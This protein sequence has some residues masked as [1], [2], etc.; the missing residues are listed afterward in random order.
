MTSPLLSDPH[1]NRHIVYP[2]NDELKAINAVFLFASSGLSKGESVILIMADSRCEPILQRLAGAGF[3]LQALRA[4]GQLE[5]LSAEELI[6]TFMP[7]DRLDERL[8]SDTLD[9]LIVRAASNSPSGKVRV[10]G[11]MVSLFLAQNEV[12]AAESLEELWNRKIQMHSI[13]LLCT[14][15]LLASGFV[16]LPLS[17]EQLHSHVLPDS[18]D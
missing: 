17:L 7:G 16:T 11:E 14:Y 13:S 10:F 1:P 8:V 18:G 9:R 15:T 5:C 4:A 2:Y 6:R 12:P 3:D